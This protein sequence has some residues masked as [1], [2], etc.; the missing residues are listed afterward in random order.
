MLHALDKLQRGN[1][2]G[3]LDP[4]PPLGHFPNV[5]KNLTEE[6]S[7]FSINPI[8]ITKIA[9]GITW[10]VMGFEIGFGR[11]N[12]MHHFSLKKKKSDFWEYVECPDFVPL[13]GKVVIRAMIKTHI[14]I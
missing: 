6:K 2:F 3:L 9:P 14:T 1:V 10:N 4:W 12:I 13:R 11:Q 5:F 8:K 7:I